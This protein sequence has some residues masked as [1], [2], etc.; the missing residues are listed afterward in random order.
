M[1]GD[2]FRHGTTFLRWR[3]NKQPAECRHELEVTPPAEL[4]GIFGS[5][6]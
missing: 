6:S 3:P 4:A 1:E 2:R 5:Y